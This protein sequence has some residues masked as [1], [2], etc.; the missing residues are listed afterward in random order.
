[1]TPEN[2]DIGIEKFK[3]ASITEPKQWSYKD[4]PDLKKMKVFNAK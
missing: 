3:T 2:A 1:M 4:Y